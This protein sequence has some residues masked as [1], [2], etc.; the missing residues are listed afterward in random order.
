MFKK[1]KYKNIP[2]IKN[3]NCCLKKIISIEKRV[4]RLIATNSK[5]GIRSEKSTRCIEKRFIYEIATSKTSDCVRLET[6][7]FF[8]ISSSYSFGQ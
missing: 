4:E 1:R 3:R 8:L 6:N 7:A 2:A 5:E